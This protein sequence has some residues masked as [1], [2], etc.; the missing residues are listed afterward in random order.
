M[1][2]IIDSAVGVVGFVRRREL[3]F[4]ERGRADLGNAHPAVSRVVRR[5]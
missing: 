3:P 2:L 1:D 4:D 5:P